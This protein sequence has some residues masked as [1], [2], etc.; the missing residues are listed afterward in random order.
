MARLPGGD[1]LQQLGDTIVAAADRAAAGRWDHALAMAQSTVGA[2]TEERVRQVTRRI[3]TEMAA[4]GAATG[5]AAALPMTGTGTAVTTGVGELGWFTMRSADLILAI[6]AIHGHTQVSVE[7]RRAWVL[8]LLVFGDGAVGGFNR[9]ASE[10]GRGLGIQGAPARGVSLAGL[11]SINGSL[12][13]LMAAKYGRR[14]GVVA[15][16]TALP[17]G[18]GA[19]VGGTANY[20]MVRT[21]A[22]QADRFFAELPPGLSLRLV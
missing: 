20:A 5:A 14:R 22:H 9:L 8:S 4:V 12:A 18:I 6:A 13:R 10:L 19:V 3:S 1:R 15:A 16:G 7:Q 21:L 2:S 17:F 11:R